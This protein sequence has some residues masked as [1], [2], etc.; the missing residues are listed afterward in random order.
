MK[1]EKQ[2]RRSLKLNC[3]QSFNTNN[4]TIGILL[5]LSFSEPPKNI[6]EK[7]LNF[8]FHNDNFN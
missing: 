5:V 8:F 7:Y 1:R 3:Y 6:E 4:V 2:C